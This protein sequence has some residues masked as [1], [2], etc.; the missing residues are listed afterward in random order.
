MV[1]SFSVGDEAPSPCPDVQNVDL[2]AAERTLRL[3]QAELRI[4]I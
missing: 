4:F 3:R 2:P 1:P